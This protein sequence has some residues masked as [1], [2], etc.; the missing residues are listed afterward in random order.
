MH[1]RIQAL[2]NELDVV[3]LLVAPLLQSRKPLARLA[4]LPSLA[5]FLKGSTLGAHHAD[6][7]PRGRQ[8]RL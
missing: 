1:I 3:K 4:Q 2:T 5:R 6:L 8:T 7:N